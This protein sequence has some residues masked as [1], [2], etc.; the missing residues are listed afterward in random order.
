MQPKWGRL[1]TA[2]ITPFNTNN[3][4]DIPEAVKLAKYLV[5]NGTDTIL[6]AGTTGESPTLS[7]EE[8][9]KLF[10]AV[11]AAVAGKAYVMA[12]TGS[13]STATAINSTKKAEE[14]GV[15]LALLVVPYYNKPSQEG[16][17]LHF[18]A[19]AENT[20][21]PIVLYNIPGRT[22]KNMEPE[23]VA[24]LASI[25]NIVGIKEAAGS[26]EQVAKLKALVPDDFLIYSG[27]D[28]LT[29]DF[30]ENGACG[31]ISVAS[32]CVGLQI[33]EMMNAFISGEKEKARAIEAKLNPLF[34]V[35]FITSNPTPV[36][37]ALEMMGFKVGKPRLPLVEATAQEKEA[38]LAVLK[39]VQTVKV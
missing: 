39:Q 4:V 36:K 7:H 20:S 1:I 38:V 16:M 22:S 29:L 8:E 5:D 26:V 33:K 28:G 31:V 25:P 15:D 11:K 17:Y 10:K 35:L 24:R 19:I 23:T 18:K 27:D 30:I 14:I 2:M 12:G 6:L 13:N 21:L 34:D 3:E 9:F 32:H 37:A